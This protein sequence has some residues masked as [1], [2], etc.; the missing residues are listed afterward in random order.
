MKTLIDRCVR[1]L[2]LTIAACL[3]LMVVL[4]FG[5]VVLRYGFNTGIVISEELSRWL[6]IWLTFLGAVVAQREHAHLGTDALVSRLPVAGKKLCLVFTQACMLYL[7]W[8][9]FQGSWEQAMIN[10]DVHAP[11]SGWS[12]AIVYLS[13]V[14]FSAFTAVLL[15]MDL[16]RAV[17]GQMSEAEL[18]MVRESEEEAELEALQARLAKEDAALAHPVAAG[19]GGVA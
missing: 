9:F 14:V 3:A 4:V 13:G 6:F 15:L 18:V 16:A 5:N 10:W 2:A 7:T 17:L 8:L 12:M 1:A 11:V 19:R